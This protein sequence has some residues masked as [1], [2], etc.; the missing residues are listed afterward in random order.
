MSILKKYK[1]SSLQKLAA[2]KSEQPPKFVSALI[3]SIV[4]PLSVDPVEA[5]ADC[6][7]RLGSTA[8]FVFEVAS[9]VL[10]Q[11]MLTL[12]L[13]IMY[14]AVMSYKQLSFWM[15]DLPA[16]LWYL[17]QSKSIFT[18]CSLMTNVLAGLLPWYVFCSA[19][20]FSAWAGVC[21]AIPVVTFAFLKEYFEAW[22]RSTWPYVHMQA[23]KA[24]DYSTTTIDGITLNHLE[25]SAGKHSGLFF[26]CASWCI[27]AVAAAAAVAAV[28]VAAA[29]YAQ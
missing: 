19:L 24:L 16:Q 5:S 17:Q 27:I 11:V 18:A 29:V 15:P 20:C 26:Q 9:F 2:S 4:V 22:A 13:G 6:D 21:A 25:R 10:L 7:A 14:V 3:L 1:V 8:C 12:A 23:K 28:V